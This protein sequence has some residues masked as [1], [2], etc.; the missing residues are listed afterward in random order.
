[1]IVYSASRAEFTKD[2]L[3]NHIEKKILDAFALRLGRRTSKA[4]VASWKNSMQ[5]M[6]NVLTSGNIPGD[7][8][9]AIEYQVPLTSK[10][11]DFI[12]SGADDQKRDTAIIV[13]LKQW[14]EVSE[15]RK[16][17][18][19]ET[20]VGGAK[21]ELTH[22][23][24]QAWTYAAL[25]RDF[26]VEVQEGHIELKPCAYLHNCSNPSAVTS[27][28]YAEHMGRAPLFLREDAEKLSD[29]LKRYV[30]YGDTSRILYKIDHGRLRPSKNLADHLVSL[31][32]GNREFEM[33]DDQKVVYETALDLAGRAKEGRKEVLLVEGGPGTGKSV[34]A[35]NLLVELTRRQF[36]A[37][38]VSRNVAPRAVYES[39]LSGSFTKT[40]ITNLFKGSGAY[41]ETASNTM[42]VLI[43]DEAHRLN[44][45]SGFYRNQGDNQIKEIIRATRC[46][47]FFLDQDQRVTLKDIGDRKEIRRWA[48]E[49]GANLTELKLESQFRCNGSDGYLSW[50][51]NAL[52]V[53]GTAN[54][55]LAGIQYDFRVF[56]S[57]NDLRAH[58]VELNKESNKARMVAGYCW[59]WKGKKNPDIED[60]TIPEHGFSMH[61][62]LDTDNSL[63]IIAPDSVS[64][65]GCIHTCQGL[66]L[67]YVGVV[68]GQDLV[69]RDG[70]VVT[71]AGKRSSQDRSIRGYKSMLRKEPETAKRLADP[72]IKNTYRTLMT[73]G[74]KGCYIFCVDAET[75]EYFRRFVEYDVGDAAGGRSWPEAAEPEPAD[76]DQLGRA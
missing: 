37:H 30:K 3:S 4:E 11:V 16:D 32:Q 73:R 53:E 46:S 28:F 62:N 69:V 5:Y 44:E 52:Q 18:I 36:V 75:N 64:E 55:T 48:A 21:R 1:M 50:V 40:H 15:T 20:F 57:P 35:I 31:L 59:D 61:W 39:K 67:D 27:A 49:A 38:Y 29:F 10:R 17:A 12:L 65:I 51:N 9:V 34:V 24:Y 68:I 19:V 14:S 58:I 74:Q 43:V 47:V 60:V 66:E 76:D 25:I 23:S 26:N 42:D 63:W 6:N 72:I 22:P 7:A 13:E 8:G 41:R 33:I 71:D 45:K 70:Q 56:D 54:P 2:V